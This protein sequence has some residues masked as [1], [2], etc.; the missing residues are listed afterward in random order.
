MIVIGAILIFIAPL[1]HRVFPKTNPEVA[2]YKKELAIAVS[3]IDTAIAVNICDLENNLIT[4]DLFIDRLYKLEAQ[5][6]HVLNENKKAIGHF[7]KQ[8]R[9]FGWN[10]T[11]SFILGLGVRLPYLLLSIILSFLIYKINTV[12]KSL[13]KWFFWLQIACYGISFYF[14][15]WVFWTSSDFPLKAY[16]WFFILF[17]II[18]A[19]TTVSFISYREVFRLKLSRI[20]ERLII[21]LVHS[22]T[23]IESESKSKKHL[24]E[25]MKEIDRIIS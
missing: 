10:T 3:S 22:D 25:T 2:A 9:V 16:R 13:K 6:K 5:K 11:R 19:I 8:R 4:K 17:S 1:L 12:D 24:E 7:V 15:F 18:A 20:V 14:M 23:Y 21:R